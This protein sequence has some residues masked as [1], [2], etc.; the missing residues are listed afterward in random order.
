M[1][2]DE[3]ERAGLR[4]RGGGGF[5]TAIKM[6][7]VAAARSRT[8]AVANG[9]EGEPASTKDKLLLSYLPHLVLDGAVAAAGAVGADEVIVCVP[10][11]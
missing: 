9:S 5:P 2:I 1:S 6:R 8:I 10:R 11:G 4:G 3:V 7:A